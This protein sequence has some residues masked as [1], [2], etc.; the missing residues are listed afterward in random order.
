MLGSW[1]SWGP[2]HLTARTRAVGSH[3]RVLFA[4]AVVAFAPTVL[5]SGYAALASFSLV[6][7]NSRSMFPSLGP[8]C[9]VL[10]WTDCR[11][12]LSFALSANLLPFP[13]APSH[14]SF[15]RA[16]SSTR[17]RSTTSF[18]THRRSLS[19][20]SMLPSV[21]Q[22][23][24]SDSGAVCNSSWCAALV[25]RDCPLML[26]RRRAGHGLHHS[27]GRAGFLLAAFSL[28]LA[29]AAPIQKA[30][31]QGRRSRCSTRLR[32]HAFCMPKPRTK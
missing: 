32:L 11:R 10:V 5:D 7:R 17:F 20:T 13:S 16:R 18:W 2:K 19:G 9:G 25:W 12:N 3:R 22:Q 27:H 8:Q 28:G 30:A 26:L 29:M 14:F 31:D 24:A 15:L 4:A 23:L 6:R 1:A 21:K